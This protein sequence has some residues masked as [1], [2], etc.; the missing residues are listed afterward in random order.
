MITLPV[1]TYFRFRYHGRWDYGQVQPGQA[2]WQLMG[3]DQIPLGTEVHECVWVGPNRQTLESRR[4]LKG[5]K[6]RKDHLKET[7]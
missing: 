2:T 7:P 3:E 1:G 5:N 6:W 4:I